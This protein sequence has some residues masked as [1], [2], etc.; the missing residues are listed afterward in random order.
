VLAAS[1]SNFQVGLIVK[2]SRAKLVT[3]K[4]IAE[5]ELLLSWCAAKVVILNCSL[6]LSFDCWILKFPPWK[7]NVSQKSC[8]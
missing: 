2:R 6:L 8:I 5:S 7:A 3:H 4:L 1:P